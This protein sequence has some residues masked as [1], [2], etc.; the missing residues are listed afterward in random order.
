MFVRIGFEN[1]AIE[2]N[3]QFSSNPGTQNIL[4][5][6]FVLLILNSIARQLIVSI[7]SKFATYAS[8]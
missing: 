8:P 6:A 1:E 2:P 4:P 5:K 7:L 3:F